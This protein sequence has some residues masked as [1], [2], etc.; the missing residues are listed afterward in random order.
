MT[1]N[2]GNISQ[3]IDFIFLFIYRVRVVVASFKLFVAILRE[4]EEKNF[5]SFQQRCRSINFYNL[6][7][8]YRLLNSLN[9]YQTISFNFPNHLSAINQSIPSAANRLIELAGKPIVPQL[10]EF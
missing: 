2:V 4:K 5:E 6:L 8:V 10:S 1:V 7:T 3:R 9:I